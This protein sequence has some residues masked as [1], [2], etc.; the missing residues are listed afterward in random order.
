MRIKIETALKLLKIIPILIMIFLGGVFIYFQL[1]NPVG[2]IFTV[3]VT[4]PIYLWLFRFFEPEIVIFLKR[5]SN[6]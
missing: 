4:I 2:I 1:L 5:K 3:I 6:L